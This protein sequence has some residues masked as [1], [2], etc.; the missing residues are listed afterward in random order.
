MR[1]WLELEI[2]QVISRK[3]RNHRQARQHYVSCSSLILKQEL[4]CS[5]INKY[6]IERNIFILKFA[7]SH[8]DKF[9]VENQ[10]RDVSQKEGFK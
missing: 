8:H 6:R 9:R 3:I 7:Q 2:T 1:P 4:H 5:I 10:I